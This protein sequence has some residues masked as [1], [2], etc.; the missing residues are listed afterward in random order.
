MTP[1]DDLDTPAGMSAANEPSWSK[2]YECLRRGLYLFPDSRCS[3]CT[4][5]TPEELV[6]RRD[7]SLL[8][9]PAPGTGDE[10]KGRVR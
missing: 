2:C 4:R 9:R 7:G 5:C 6:C 10:L 3:H 8:E 1:T